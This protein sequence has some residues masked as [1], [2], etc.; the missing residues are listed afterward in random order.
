MADVQRWTPGGNNVV[1]TELLSHSRI[2]TA[3]L[4]AR[5]CTRPRYASRDLVQS[6]FR[7]MQRRP[8]IGQDGV[9]SLGSVPLKFTG[10]V[11]VHVR[12]NLDPAVAKNLGHSPQGHTLRQEQ[13][14]AIVTEAMER[15]GAGRAERLRALLHQSPRTFDKPSSVWTLELAAQVSFEQ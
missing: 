4:S 7:R 3:D 2:T 1:T 15:V 9:H 14:G 12:G 11:P 10:E 13:A 5:T 6:S 8:R